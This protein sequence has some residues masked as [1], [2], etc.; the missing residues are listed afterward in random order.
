MIKVIDH[1]CSCHSWRQLLLSESEAELMRDILFNLP[2]RGNFHTF[3]C[4]LGH[5]HRLSDLIEMEKMARA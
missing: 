5:T 3:I 1:G 4:G 2:R